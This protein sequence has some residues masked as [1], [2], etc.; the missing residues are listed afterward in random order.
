MPG[1]VAAGS[2]G[3]CINVAGGGDH[4][5]TG[6]PFGFYF[7]QEGGWGATAHRDGWTSVPNPTSNFNDYPAEALR[8]TCRCG[9]S[10]WR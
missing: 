8:P 6:E 7:F 3:T 5:V 10:R 9:W 2:Y 4:P 1:K